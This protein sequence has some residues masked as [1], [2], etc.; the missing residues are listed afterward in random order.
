MTNPHVPSGID[1][2][3]AQSAELERQRAELDQARAKLDAANTTAQTA[4]SV[5]VVIDPDGGE[6]ELN[7]DGTVYKDEDGQPVPKWKYDTVTV[8]GRVIQARQPQPAAIQAFTMATSKHSSPKT[9]NEMVAMFVRNHI[10][11]RSYQ[12]LLT[13]MMDPDDAFTI[14]SFGELM[15]EIATLGT[16]RPT[17]PSQN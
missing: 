15:R 16:A 3:A 8:N 11:P 9:Q 1:D 10:S 7:D 4:V 13:A 5:P 12:E 17:P 6:Y 2:L 14:E